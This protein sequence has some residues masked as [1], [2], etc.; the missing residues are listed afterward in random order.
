MSLSSK[1]DKVSKLFLAG[2]IPILLSQ[3]YD[4]DE[5]SKLAQMMLQDFDRVAED[6]TKVLPRDYSRVLEIQSAAVT[7]GDALDSPKVW[8]KIL[9]V[10]AR[11]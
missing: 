8:A 1:E 5:I 4:G 6:F 2:H 3:I 9:E 7:A 10:S 11:G